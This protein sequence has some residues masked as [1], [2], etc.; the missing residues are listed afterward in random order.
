[1]GSTRH[2]YGMP[3]YGYG[4]GKPDPWVTRSKPYLS[5][6]MAVKLMAIVMQ[7]IVK[8][9][10]MKQPNNKESEGSMEGEEDERERRRE[11]EWRKRTEQTSVAVVITDV[12]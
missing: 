11:R 6:N 12:F 8:Q 2:G 4:V 7:M 3:W 10:R 5:S 9:C 1:M